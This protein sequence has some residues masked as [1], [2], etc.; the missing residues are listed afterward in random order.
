MQTFGE[1]LRKHRLKYNLSITE[2]AHR[3]N[4][5]ISHYIN[6][7]NNCCEL[8]FSVLRCLCKEFQIDLTALTNQFPRYQ[9]AQNSAVSSTD[10]SGFAYTIEVYYTQLPFY[11]E[12][13]CIFRYVDLSSDKQEIENLVELMNKL[14]L[15]I[16]QIDDVIEDFISRSY[17]CH[18]EV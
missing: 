15:P 14:Q 18:S 13:N 11:S 5:N 17:P 7:E 8:T 1:Y 16:Y 12:C 9:I 10:P 6:L 2:V 3:C 4:L